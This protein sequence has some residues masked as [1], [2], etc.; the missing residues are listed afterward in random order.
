MPLISSVKSCFVPLI[1]SGL[2]LSTLL[3]GTAWQSPGSVQQEMDHLSIQH[4]DRSGLKSSI[5]CNHQFGELF[6]WMLHHW[7]EVFSCL[8]SL[9]RIPDFSVSTH[10]HQ[11]TCSIFVVHWIGNSSAIWVLLDKKF[12]F[13]FILEV[14]IFTFILIVI[15]IQNLNS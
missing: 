3:I 4:G 13:P 7:K 2:F 14:Y 6:H 9:G 12:F 11:W 15:A 10:T 8:I 5:S 1:I